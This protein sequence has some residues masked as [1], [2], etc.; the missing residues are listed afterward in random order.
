MKIPGGSG[1]LISVQCFLLVPRQNDR[2]QVVAV[3]Y[4]VQMI[5]K[6]IV[7]LPKSAYDIVGDQLR[8]LSEVRV[9]IVYRSKSGVTEAKT[10]Y[11]QPGTKWEASIPW[12]AQW[13]IG[14]TT[15]Y[16][17]ESLVH[18][19]LY[20][21]RFFR[22]VSDDVFY[23]LLDKSGIRGRNVRWMFWSVRLG[24]FVYYA[25]D[26]SKFWRFVRKFI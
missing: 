7:Q 18:D 3:H 19:E 9:N 16:P 13:I 22:S 26:S 12:W 24:G 8:L 4:G 17:L 10:L 5:K 6:Q 20:K 14:K 21:E 1:R 25:S 11:I 23:Y 2:Q 15:D